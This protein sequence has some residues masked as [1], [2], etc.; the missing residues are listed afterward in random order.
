[1]VNYYFKALDPKY[2]AN[3]PL[4]IHSQLDK[5]VGLAMLMVASAVFLYYTVWTLLM[6][7]IQRQRFT[8]STD[9][10]II[11]HS[12]LLIRI[13]QSRTYS[14]H[15]SGPSVYLLFSF[16]SVLLSLAHS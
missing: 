7:H 9:L 11:F 2:L 4:L 14:L 12:H 16:Y 5:L 1:M 10:L 13:N 6:V 8:S 15:E 3:Q